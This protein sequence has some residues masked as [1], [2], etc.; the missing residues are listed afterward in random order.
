MVIWHYRDRTLLKCYMGDT[1]LLV[2]LA[3]GENELTV[4]EIEKRILFDSIEINQ[5][6]LFENLVAQMLVASGHKLYFFMQSGNGDA[7]EKMEI[8]FLISKPSITR[9]KNISSIEVKSSRQYST[10]SLDKF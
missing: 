8:D 7:A 4:H 6:M 2:S 3:F 10:A 9:R 1:G 5:G